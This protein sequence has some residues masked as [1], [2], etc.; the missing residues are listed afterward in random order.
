VGEV[1]APEIKKIFFP[2]PPPPPNKDG[3]AKNI[4]TKSQRLAVAE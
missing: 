3:P 2:P 1:V 4:Y